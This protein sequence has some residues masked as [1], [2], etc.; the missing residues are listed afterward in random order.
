MIEYAPIAVYHDGVNHA[1]RPFLR[2]IALM[3]LA[4]GISV[5]I[6]AWTVHDAAHGAM[7]VG[8]DDHHHHDDGGRIS[9][10]EHD[11]DG[12]D[13]EAPDGGHDHMPSILLG[14]VTLSDAGVP[15]AGPIAGRQIFTIPPSRGIER[16]PSSGLR[17]PP[18]LG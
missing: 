18:R 4:L 17:R 12:H 10:H 9:V 13:G 1:I 3:W 6:A 8:I 11:A 14:A 15:V 7:Q 5:P 2:L 16:Y